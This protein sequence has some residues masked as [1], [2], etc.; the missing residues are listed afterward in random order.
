MDKFGVVID[1]EL[2]KIA[3]KEGRPCPQCGSKSVNYEGTTPH[4]PNC[5]TRPWEINGQGSDHRL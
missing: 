2:E 1:E 5:G 4:C 3:S